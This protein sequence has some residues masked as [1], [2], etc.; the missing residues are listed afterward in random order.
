MMSVTEGQ[1]GESVMALGTGAAA[2]VYPD[3]C[4]VEVS[5][6]PLWSLCRRPLLAKRRSFPKP[7]EG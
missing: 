2:V 7:R 4:R 3:G 6:K 5:A 1:T